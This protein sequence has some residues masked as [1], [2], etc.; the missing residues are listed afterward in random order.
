MVHAGLLK[1]YLGSHIGAICPNGF[2]ADSENHCAHFVSHALGL[3]FGMTCARLVH[4]SRHHGAGAN[5]RVQE[6]FAA[7][8]NVRELLECPT[9]G[10]ALI[11]VSAPTNF[12]AKTH[13]MRNV[14]K[15][16]VGILHNGVMWHYSNRERRVVSQPASQFLFH[17]PG[18]TNA[19]WIGDLPAS[20]RPTAPG[21]L[22]AR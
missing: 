17:Y 22:S 13:T 9:V 21:A 10:T 6:L 19:L 12:S 18:Q 1:S 20:A 2:D 5:V 15:K 4:R 11:F 16:H 14:P 3:E 8:P 7:C